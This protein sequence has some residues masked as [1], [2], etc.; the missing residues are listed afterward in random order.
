MDVRN[1]VKTVASLFGSES[2]Q[3]YAGQHNRTRQNRAPPKADRKPPPSLT[4]GGNENRTA[5]AYAAPDENLKFD[6][7]FSQLV[8]KRRSLVAG[9]LELIGLEDVRSALG[10]KWAL[11]KDTV[12]KLTH[13][14][15]RRSLDPSDIFRRHGDTSF[16]I[17]F[18]HLNK[19]AAEER[20]HHVASQIRHTLVQSIPEVGRAISAR[21]FVAVIESA[22]IDSSG[23][24][25][26]ALFARL[27]NIRSDAVADLRRRRKSLDQ[28]TT[29][30]FSPI[31]DVRKELALLHHCRVS[32]F[33]HNRLPALWRELVPP[34]EAT[35]IIA[36]MDYLVLTKTLE[37]LHKFRRHNQP[38][39]LLIPVDMRTISSTETCREYIRLLG[40]VPATY[41]N[42]I[43]LEVCRVDASVTADRIYELVKTLGPHIKE[44]VVH[45]PLDDK[46]I[47]DI[48]A[49]GVWALST[50]ITGIDVLDRSS[51]VPLRRFAAADGVGGI[52][53][54]ARGAN[55]IGLAIAAV[56]AGF[57]MVEG[58]AISAP[59]R[60]PRLEFRLRVQALL[61]AQA[62][63][64]QTNVRPPFSER[65]TSH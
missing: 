58:A 41:Q 56:N 38:A 47:T 14:E 26:D 53:T 60:E 12:I 6:E 50:D 30:L 55:S 32:T 4:I 61:P 9:S 3:Q 10:P 15:L 1:L 17:H 59:A 64:S 25:A 23:G 45:L 13:D 39:P 51:I 34:E 24:I 5:I 48:A 27:T 46:R 37:A 7:A 11:F 8:G 62:G 52:K 33:R 21:P 42:Y 63:T 19:K 29:I 54:I 22:E 16:L 65:T 36:E 31:W 35:G 2:D 44:L 18:D 20:A 57:T 49:S 40:A 43:V 28:N